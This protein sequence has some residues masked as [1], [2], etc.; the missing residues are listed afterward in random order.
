MD[1]YPAGN[2]VYLK[3]L[4]NYH[5]LIAILTLC[6][7][8][9]QQELFNFKT[10]CVQYQG[11]QSDWINMR[12]IVHKIFFLICDKTV[13][14]ALGICSFFVWKFFFCSMREN[15]LCRHGRRKVQNAWVCP[16]RPCGWLDR[17]AIHSLYKDGHITAGCFQKMHDFLL[18]VLYTVTSECVHIK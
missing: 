2:S 4:V 6:K 8:S 18:H 16:S 13:K 15:K 12:G 14:K 5:G 11:R 10:I 1:C 7:I 9:M 17:Y 3:I